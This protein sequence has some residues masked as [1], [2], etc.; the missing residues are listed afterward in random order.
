M[1]IIYY[2]FNENL[3]K[4]SI[5][6]QLYPKSTKMGTFEQ[7]Y[8][9]VT[10]LFM[11]IPWLYQFYQQFEKYLYFGIFYLQPTSR[12]FTTKIKLNFKN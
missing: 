4:L 12:L 8:S 7:K 10:Y 5:K 6:Y 11:T 3:N 9:Y 2:F 1:N